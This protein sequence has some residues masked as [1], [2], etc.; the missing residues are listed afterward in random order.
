MKTKPCIICSRGLE[1]AGLGVVHQP[2]DAVAFYSKGNY[3]STVFD[4][5]D[6]TIQLEIN[7]C[8]S[9]LTAA[10]KQGSV[11]IVQRIPEII[12]HLSDFDGEPIGPGQ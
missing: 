9:C 7:I 5:L 2:N 1:P 11:L 8:D 6:D 3:G 12:E 4:P 10:A